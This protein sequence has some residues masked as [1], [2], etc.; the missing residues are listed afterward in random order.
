MI[1]TTY[2]FLRLFLRLSIVAAGAQKDLL[3]FC[4]VLFT[5]ALIIA[6]STSHTSSHHPARPSL[7]APLLASFVS[8]TCSQ[9]FLLEGT[10]F[11][12][13]LFVVTSGW[14]ARQLLLSAHSIETHRR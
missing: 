13:T 1:Q 7:A 8:L 3:I 5:T 9:R 12:V 11:G 4:D 14:S 6:A 2:F 10:E